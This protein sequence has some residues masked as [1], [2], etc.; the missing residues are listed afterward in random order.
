MSST[1]GHLTEV[2]RVTVRFAGDSGDG[3]QLTGTQF[4]TTSAI[5]GNDVA[6]F[7]DY[8]AE[9]RAPAGTLPGVSGFQIQFGSIDIRT[10]G[11]SPDVLVAMNPAALKVNLDDLHEGATIVANADAFSANNLK[12]AGYEGNPLEDGSLAGYRLIAQPITELTREALAD[13]EL[14]SGSKDRCKNFFALG[15]MFWL[16]DRPLE[17]TLE[18]IASKFKRLEVLVE[19]NQ[20]ALKAGYYFAETSELFTTHFKVRP[21]KHLPTGEYRQVMGNEAVALGLTTAAHKAG[22]DLFYGSYPITPASDVLH[23]LSKYK[24]MGVKTFQA[25]DEIAAVAAAIGAAYGGALA[26]TGTSGP[27]VALKGEAIGLAVMTELPLVIVNVQRAGPSTGMPTKTEQADLLQ[28]MF[29]RNG[30]CP[31]GI[32]APATPAECFEMAIEAARLALTHMVPVFLLTDGYL[33]NGAEP[34]RIPDPASIPEIPVTFA[35]ADGLGPDGFQGYAHDPE[36]LARPWAVPGTPGLEH[37]IGGLE[38]WDGSG[39]ISYDPANHHHMCTLRADKIERMAVPDIELD[40]PDEGD[41]LVVSWGGTYGSILSAAEIAR[42]DGLSI[43]VAHLRYLNP[44]PKNLGE[45]LGRFEK[46]VVPELNLGQL[47]SLL[48]ARFLVPAISYP[49]IAGRPFQIGELVAKFHEIARG[50]A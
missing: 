38:K 41:L 35:T 23:Y 34:W 29:G 8:P 32:V 6:T 37:R 43:S 50:D 40:G 10:P 25:E 31:V 24:Q 26:V 15:A 12:K 27:G 13:V 4:T 9:I 19:A 18:W 39:N 42:S 3:M 11:D 49:K 22:L 20:K 7:P 5:V 36:T 28:A 1:A 17:P 14:D 21:A 33:A 47:C 30:E 48:R 45:I 2:D 16:Y 46:V 44:F